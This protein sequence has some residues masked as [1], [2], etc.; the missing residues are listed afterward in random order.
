VLFTRFS[1]AADP[2]SPDDLQR[3]LVGAV[4]RRGEIGALAEYE[5]DVH[6]AG[7]PQPIMTYVATSSVV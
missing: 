3:L 5:M 7:N 6:L 2:H 4:R 1:S